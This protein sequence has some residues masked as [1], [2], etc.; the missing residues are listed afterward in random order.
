MNTK[1]K[2]YIKNHQLIIST[3][4]RMLTYEK[5][6]N[7][8]IN[9][10][11]EECLISKHTFYSHFE[12]KEMLIKSI[13]NDLFMQ[14]TILYEQITPSSPI[15]NIHLLQDITYDYVDNHLNIFFAFF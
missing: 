10:L 13:M 12:N 15:E 5:Y 9:K 3:F 1:D 2:R 7:I 4:I 6:E 11:C 8:T 14:L